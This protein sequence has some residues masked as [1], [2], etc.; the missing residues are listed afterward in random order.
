MPKLRILYD[1]HR[2]NF[3]FMYVKISTIE[4]RMED[5]TPTRVKH[6]L[7]LCTPWSSP[8]TDNKTDSLPMTSHWGACMNYFCRRKVVSITYLSVRA[9]TC[10][11]VYVY[12]AFLFQH[13]ACM[14][15]IV[16]SFVS[17]QPPPN[18]STLSH[19]RCDFRKKCIWRKMCVLIFS[20]AFV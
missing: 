9:W 6:A 3:T 15:H 14:R 1:G 19:K 18:F 16:T 8:I 2:Y 13:A 10:A 5:C 17:P 12:A 4:E 7:Y 20:T 11:C